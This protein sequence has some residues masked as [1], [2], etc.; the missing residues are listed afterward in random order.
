MTREQIKVKVL[1]KLK[2]KNF[3]SNAI[4]YISDYMYYLFD[5]D[6][7][8][9]E[10]NID[11]LLDRLSDELDR[12]IFFKT[13]EQELYPEIA[14]YTKMFKGFTDKN[15]KTLYVRTSNSDWEIVFYH[16]LTHILQG[17]GLVYR[18]E[19]NSTCGKLENEVITQ[20][21]ADMIYQAKEN[22][23][24]EYK[25]YD[26]KDLRMLPGIKIISDLTNYQ[27][28]DFIFKKF[29]NSC[30][31]SRKE[32]AKIMFLDD[33]IKVKEFFY[34]MNN[35]PKDILKSIYD[36][37]QYIYITDLY[38][39]TQ[40]KKV[41]DEETKEN[42]TISYRELLLDKK[43]VEQVSYKNEKRERLYNIDAQ[44]Q[45]NFYNNLATIFD[46]ISPQ[47]DRDDISDAEEIKETQ[48][49]I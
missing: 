13:E 25:E 11:I 9:K 12:I 6:L 22:K 36:Y 43:L 28:Y 10:I 19:Q 47:Q 49:K 37:F 18:D 30:N 5:L 38:I 44:T 8:S 7:V 26:S 41:I 1:E 2:N 16:E 45:F 33:T 27:A 48:K 14:S 35:L 39:Y 21:V 23:K 40:E 29:L 4:E 34:N 32:V 46:M 42:K 15:S 24:K 20:Y 17:L 3:S 31:L